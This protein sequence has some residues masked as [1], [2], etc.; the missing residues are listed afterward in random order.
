MPVQRRGAV[1]SQTT[2]NFLKG[3]QDLNQA[4]SQCS[5]ARAG[6]PSATVFARARS[7]ETSFVLYQRYKQWAFET[8]CYG[9]ALIEVLAHLINQ[10]C[11]RGAFR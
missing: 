4:R 9:D 8:Q 10:T 7:C 5:A 3:P 6:T 11:Q 1:Q 2:A